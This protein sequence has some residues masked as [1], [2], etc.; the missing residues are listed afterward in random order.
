MGEWRKR[1]LQPGGSERPAQ[2][3]GRPGQHVVRA[4]PAD[5]VLP[6]GGTMA[7]TGMLGALG[8]VLSFRLISSCS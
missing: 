8:V 4:Q 1:K 7:A 2:R 6:A 3:G 5:K